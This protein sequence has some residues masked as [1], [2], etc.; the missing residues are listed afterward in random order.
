MKTG[1]SHFVTIIDA[2]DYYRPYGFSRADVDRK[3]RD[4]EIHIGAPSVKD[5]E[6]LGVVRGEGRYFIE[7]GKP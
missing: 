6:F 2:Y 7:D 3:R 1:T 4:G 5:G